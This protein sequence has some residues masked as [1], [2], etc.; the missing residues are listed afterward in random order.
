M[1]QPGTDPLAGGADPVP[2]HEQRRLE[3]RLEARLQE[4][5]ARIVLHDGR[6]CRDGRPGQP[7]RSTG[8]ALSARV[9]SRLRALDRRLDAI[10]AR[11]DA[12]KAHLDATDARVTTIRGRLNARWWR[13]RRVV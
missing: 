4:V 2:R 13:R 9:D 3:A 7:G 6:V 5:N 1:T 11:F 12:I 10:E 8:D